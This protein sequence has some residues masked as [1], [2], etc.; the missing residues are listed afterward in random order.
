MMS[1]DQ[2]NNERPSKS[3]LKRD[4]DA[5]Q[6][7]GVE[8]MEL[9]RDQLKAL[10]IPDTLRDAVLLAK[11]ITSNGAIKRQRQYIG[12]L[13][14]EV[15]VT[16]IRACLDRIKG[17]SDEHT[18]WLHRLERW[19]EELLADDEALAEFLDDYPQADVQALRTAL[20]NA[21]KE[22]LDGKP[23]KA[24]RQIFQMLKEL[25]A[26]PSAI[27]ADEAAEHG[28]DLESDDDN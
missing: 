21:R 25:I 11:T 3:Q 2:E 16:P 26:E 9:S 1:E 8:L 19:R 27:V 6:N 7:L 24:Y 20:R 18:A 4:M 5:L 23:P 15:D 10:D 14:R 28:D 17:Q 12:R 22:K 13:M